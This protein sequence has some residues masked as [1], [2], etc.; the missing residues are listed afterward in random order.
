VEI[1]KPNST[2]LLNRTGNH[3]FDAA[4][5]MLWQ[6]VTAYGG[7]VK[8]PF[9]LRQAPIG[10]MKLDFSEDAERN[11]LITARRVKLDPHDQKFAKMGKVK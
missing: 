4:M 8:L 10:E 7:M 1:T 11:L 5:I 6:V 2:H 9:R 3:H